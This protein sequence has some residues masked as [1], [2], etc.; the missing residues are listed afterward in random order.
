MN[1]FIHF[2]DPPEYNKLVHDKIRA[3][4]LLE[5]FM[6]REILA[7]TDDADLEKLMQWIAEKREFVIKPRFGGMGRGVEVVK[8]TE[9]MD[10]KRYLASKLRSGPQIIEE[11]IEQHSE[12]E[13][14][15]PDSLNTIRI[16]TVLSDGQVHVLGAVLRIGNGK[17]TD[18]M[19]SGGLAAAVDLQ[20]GEIISNG[21]M[22]DITKT[23]NLSTHPL[24]G[25]KIRGF[26]VPYWKETLCLVEQMSRKVPMF[27]TIGWDIAI[28]QTGPILVEFNREWMTDT[29]QIPY[30]Q[31]RLED[32]LPYMDKRY[33]Y[34]V[35]EMYARKNL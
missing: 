28:S 35:H 5:E 9:G 29:F 30:N 26:I 19:S 13:R 14:L 23:S 27:K 17:K 15:H 33:L 12:M 3:F 24:T 2:A 31:G 25:Q 18:N 34:P 7:L 8:Y 16:Q 22:K 11:V 4:E 6:R 32:L 21:F 1:S 20:S 10:L